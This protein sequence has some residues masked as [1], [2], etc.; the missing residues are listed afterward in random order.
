MLP[1]SMTKM[2]KKELLELIRDQYHISSARFSASLMH[3]M[4][5]KKWQEIFDECIARGHSWTTGKSAAF[6][7]DTKW[8]GIK[9]DVLKKNDKAL[10][11]TDTG[12]TWLTDMDR[13]VLDFIGATSATVIGLSILESRANEEAEEQFMSGRLLSSV[14][15][16]RSPTSTCL[17]LT[18]V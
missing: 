3:E 11:Q 4:K 15:R 5:T 2:E 13:L 10:N 18:Q 17:M 16:N 12:R 1:V 6:L 14:T 8:P 9:R 7:K